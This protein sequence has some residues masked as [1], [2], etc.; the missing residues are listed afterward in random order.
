MF[1]NSL[2]STHKTLTVFQLKRSDHMKRDTTRT[3]I[4]VKDRVYSS[5]LGQPKHCKYPAH[6]YVVGCK[7]RGGGLT[8]GDSLNSSMNDILCLFVVQ[9]IVSTAHGDTQYTANKQTKK[10][11]ESHTFRRQKL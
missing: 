5:L 7:E 2:I 4:S 10:H 11:I 6:S 1:T 9:V 3:N 8:Y